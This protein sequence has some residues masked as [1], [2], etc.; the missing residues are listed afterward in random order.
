MGPHMNGC[1][2]TRSPRWIHAGGCGPAGAG[3]SLTLNPRFACAHLGLFMFRPA[4]ASTQR[5][6]N[7]EP[8]H[9][10]SWVQNAV[11]IHRQL[12]LSMQL[13]HL[14]IGCPRPPTFLGQTNAMFPCYDATPV[15]HLPEQIV[16]CGVATRLG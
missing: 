2:L 6:T 5:S 7:H 9:K 13:P 3:S 4:G 10:L 15:Q 8:L 11:G 14:C 1:D 12:D 16:Q